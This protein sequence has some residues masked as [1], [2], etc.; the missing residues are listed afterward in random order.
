MHSGIF[1]FLIWGDYDQT[2]VRTN[3]SHMPLY[4]AVHLLFLKVF[5]S[6]D[7]RL[8]LV[9]NYLLAYLSIINISNILRLEG[10]QKIFLIF[11]TFNPL[12]YHYT[13]IIRPEWLNIFLLTCIW[14]ALASS[15]FIVAG[16]LLA[17][18]G[19]T[20]HFAVFFVPCVAFII[21]HRETGWV[22]R[23]YGVGLVALTTTICMSPYI[24]YVISNWA[25]F[26]LQ[27]VTNQLPESVSNS[28]W[29]Y[30]KSF[31]V[32]LF[33]PSVG[34][35]NYAGRIAR[36]QVDLPAVAVIASIVAIIL[37]RVR[38]IKAS[39]VT[40]E[41]GALWLFLNLGCSVTTYGVY[42]TF[43]LTVFAVSLLRDIFPDVAPAV[44]KWVLVFAA[45]LIA[46]QI[47]FYATVFTK[48]FKTADFKE[49]VRCLSADIPQ[50]AKTYVLANPDPSVELK[51][52]RPDLDIRRYVDFEKYSD[53]WKAVVPDNKYFV[54]SADKNVLDRYDYGAVLRTERKKG[55]LK[56]KACDVGNSHFLVWSR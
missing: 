12:I 32:P 38:H 13:N 49:A 44:R 15:R 18:A 7:S 45:I 25:D 37:K 21:W 55:A 19:L 17:L 48:I 5:G 46:Y 35:Y 8:L 39:P 41:A 50:F 1:R 27:L 28:N 20:H 2:F 26:K 40:V 24:Y 43:F 47:F 51:N 6:T 42:V 30:V 31:L 3:F 52:L 22:R 33:F 4:P 11:V 34:P 16:C 36:W 56:E 9:L 10:R 14:R 53:R 23:L 29:K 54:I